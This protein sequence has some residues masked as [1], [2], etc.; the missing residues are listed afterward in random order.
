LGA[1][2]RSILQYDDSVVKVGHRVIQGEHVK[3]YLGGE[4]CQVIR[5]L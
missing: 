5:R 1:F 3:I 2:S 4:N